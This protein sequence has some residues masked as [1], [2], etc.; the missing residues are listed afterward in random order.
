MSAAIEEQEEQEE[1]DRRLNPWTVVSRSLRMSL[2]I[3]FML[4]VR[5]GQA[6]DELRQGERHQHRRNDPVG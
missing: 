5:A 2:I 4:H 1:R 3:T 6:A